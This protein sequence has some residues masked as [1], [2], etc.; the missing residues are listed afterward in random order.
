MFGDIR[1]AQE[2]TNFQSQFIAGVKGIAPCTMIN[3][4]FETTQYDVC[5]ITPW[6]CPSGQLPYKVIDERK[7]ATDYANDPTSAALGGF[8]G[9]CKVAPPLKDADGQY[10]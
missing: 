6:T 8:P 2:L 5:P 3:K 9:K 10:A 7:L 4:D 1:A